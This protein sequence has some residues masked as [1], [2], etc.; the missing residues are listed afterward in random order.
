MGLEALLRW[1]H[2]DLGLVGPHKFI[3]IAERNGRILSIGEWV[4][5][6]ACAQTRQWQARGLPVVPVAVN[7]SAIQFRSEGFSA[8]VRNVLE[9]T[10][11]RPQLLELELT[12]SMLFQNAEAVRESVRALQA[13]GVKIAI[14]DFGTGYSSLSYLKQF[15]VNK[16]KIDRSFIRD[17]PGDHDDEVI[18]EA[19]ISMGRSLNLTV[20][21]EGVETEGQMAFLKDHDCDQIQGYWYSKPASPEEIASNLEAQL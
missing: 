3:P 16:L 21:A 4:L 13:A 19:I 18:A 12:E 10:G 1:K 8:Q 7:V 14:D 15:R 11:L 6:T 20:I 5:R 9:E 2:P 17:I